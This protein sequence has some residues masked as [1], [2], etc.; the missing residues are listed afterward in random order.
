[1]ETDQVVFD[2]RVY[3]VRQKF[4]RT[5]GSFQ[6]RLVSARGD[7]VERRRTFYVVERDQ[8]LFWVKEYTEPAP[9]HDIYYEFTE[10]QRLY[11]ATYVGRNE[12]QTVQMFGVEN[13]RLLMEY[14]DGY[15][16]LHEMSLT[17]PQQATVGQLIA[18]WIQEHPEV[19]NYDMCGNNILIKINGGISIRLIDFEYSIKMSRQRWEHTRNAKCWY[20]KAGTIPFLGSGYDSRKKGK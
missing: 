7:K 18:K 13:G 2:N 9:Y 4:Y 19:H 12:I 16:K 17:P 20:N 6:Q 5:I 14:C 11:S 15:V 8:Q 1:V 3:V 10:T